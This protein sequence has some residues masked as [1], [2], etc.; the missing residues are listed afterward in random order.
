MRIK[1]D[2]PV[3]PNRI[4]SRFLVQDTYQRFILS[5]HASWW[6]PVS[7]FL[8]VVHIQC[9]DPL[10]LFFCIFAPRC[11]SAFLWWCA[12]SI[13]VLLVCIQRDDPFAPKPRSR[14][15][16]KTVTSCILVLSRL[17]SPS[18]WW[19]ASSVTTR[20]ASTVCL[21][22]FLLQLPP[23]GDLISLPAAQSTGSSF[24]I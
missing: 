17:Q 7:I 11:I 9:D 20:P 10:H 5:H 19:C 1:R 15:K 13:L 16:T 18:W 21:P 24:Q 3:A 6:S 2:D 8:A 12:S 14:R 4:L 23:L 22:L